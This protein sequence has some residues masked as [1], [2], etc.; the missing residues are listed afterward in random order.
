MNS[1]IY[2]DDLDIEHR[3]Y[4][5]LKREGYNTVADLHEAT[6]K[7]LMEMPGFGISCLE[8][9]R[10]K[11]APYGVAINFDDNPLQV[12]HV[13]RMIEVG[14]TTPERLA[15]AIGCHEEHAREALAICLGG[16]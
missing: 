14:Y 4:N 15:A 11:L 5:C 13:R 6:V 16:S 10:D 2:L 1:E 3:T 7:D 8:D 12:K 9:L